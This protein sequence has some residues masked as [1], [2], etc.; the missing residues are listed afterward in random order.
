M[1]ALA[2]A[3]LVVVGCSPAGQSVISPSPA[4]SPPT[5]A[6]TG[7][8]VAIAGP[9]V[10]LR[11]SVARQP[12]DAAT[13]E[14]LAQ[15]VA[16]D[17]NFALRLYRQIVSTERGNVFISP[18]SISTALSMAYAGARGNTAQEMADVMGIWPDAGA[19]HAAR[20]RLDLE[21]AAAAA[22]D[23]P[24]EGEVVPLTLEPVNTFFGQA[25]FP[26]EPSFLDVLAASY[27]AGMNTVDFAN[28]TE[29]ARLAI[30]AWVAER[31][32]D[33]IEEL[34]AQGDLTDLTRFVLVNAI[35]FKASWIR[36]FNPD[37]TRTEPFQLLGGTSADVPM[38]HTN[39]KFE[40]ASGEGWQAVRVPYFGASMVIVVPDAGRFSDVEATIDS[41]VLAAM[42]AQM[43]EAMVDLGLPRWESE[44]RFDLLDNLGRMGIVDLFDPDA[45]DLSGVADTRQL[46]VSHVIHQ[47]NVTVDENG[48]EAAAATAIVGDEVSAPNRYVTLTID[49]PFLY[50][51]QDNTTGEILFLGRT[52]TP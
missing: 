34:L 24:G 31:T 47:A 43:S 36:K 46:Y 11:S 6:P 8:P 2:V 28:D 7:S 27:G 14:Q 48:T 40:Y 12:I 15:L 18:Y 33:R 22:R 29:A 10:E 4:A 35:Y 13:P 26:F 17:A 30:N 19:W 45:A 42:S 23:W 25:D 21:L 5:A 39:Q 44:S 32:H 20:N 51:I 1:R 37:Q 38:M 41:D 16:A 3:L 9:V 52:L 50:F 49:R